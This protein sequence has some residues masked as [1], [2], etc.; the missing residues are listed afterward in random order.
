MSKEKQNIE[1]IVKI[2][3]ADHGDCDD[4]PYYVY[5]SCPNKEDAEQ[6]HNAGFCKRDEVIDEFAN[7]LKEH[8]DDTYTK[9]EDVLTDVHNLI[10]YLVKKM[11]G[12]QNEEGNQK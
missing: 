10:D 11:K 12:E 2:L 5:E 6:L 9:S 1:G 8:L 7:L 3:C 4:C